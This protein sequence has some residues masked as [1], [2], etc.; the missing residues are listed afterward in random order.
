MPVYLKHINDFSELERV[1]SVL[2]VPC[3]FCPAASMAVR[4]NAPY[5]EVLKNRMP[6]LTERF[7][8]PVPPGCN[9]PCHGKK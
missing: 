7:W 6:A 8:R 9:R 3:R 2:I 1:E 5:F 4:K